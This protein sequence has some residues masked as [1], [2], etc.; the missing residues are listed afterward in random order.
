M[1]TGSETDMPGK[2]RILLL[3]EFLE[4]MGMSVDNIINMIIGQ[5]NE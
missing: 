1:I 2:S 4:A 5:N 3:K